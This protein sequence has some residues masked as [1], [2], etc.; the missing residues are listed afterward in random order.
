MSIRREGGLV[1]QILLSADGAL[2]LAMP[3]IE[4][5]PA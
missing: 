5:T 3:S 4:E 1:L 2:V